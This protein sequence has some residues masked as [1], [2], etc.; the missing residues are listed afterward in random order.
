MTAELASIGSGSGW[1]IPSTTHNGSVFPKIVDVPRMVILGVLPIREDELTTTIPGI[2][3]CSIWS[4]ELYAG[5]I[6]SSAFTVV[7][8][9]T[10]SLRGR[11]LYP[12][13]ITVTS[14][15]WEASVFMVIFSG[16]SSV[17]FITWVCIPMK[18]NIKE[19]SFSPGNVMLKFPFTS[20]ETPMLVSL[21]ST[22]TPGRALPFS[23]N[24]VPLMVLGFCGFS[25]CSLT[26]TTP[27]T[28]E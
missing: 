8:A 24:T 9:P 19:L 11:L 22:V 18:E 21:T 16:L 1:M 5:I 12:V 15:N 13:D 27:S 10:M 6:M 2:F 17:H 25:G 26:T 7:Y 3:P 4:M 23:S 28:M 14:S 20:V